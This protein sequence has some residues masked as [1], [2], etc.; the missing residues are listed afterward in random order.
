MLA[1]IAARWQHRRLCFHR[2]I[3]APRHSTQSNTIRPNAV[4]KSRFIDTFDLICRTSIE[5]S[6]HDKTTGAGAPVAYGS[7]CLCSIGLD[8]HRLPKGQH[9][10]MRTLVAKARQMP[11]RSACAVA[12]GLQLACFV[13][14]GC[15][16]RDAVLSLA[17]LV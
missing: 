12:L 8:V 9:G 17:V 16:W 4:M 13:V 6:R 14:N 3:I 5:A 15:D 2:P 1:T 11:R 7:L 10:L